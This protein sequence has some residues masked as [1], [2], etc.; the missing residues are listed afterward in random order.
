MEDDMKMNEAGRGDNLNQA[1]KKYFKEC[2]NR[3]K[4][5]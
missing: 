3:K 1:P 5:A 2:R 4:G